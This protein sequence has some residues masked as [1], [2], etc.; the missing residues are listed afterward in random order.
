MSSEEFH[1]C[2]RNWQRL[3]GFL[4]PASWYRDLICCMLSV[5]ASD[6]QLP[7]VWE[8]CTGHSQ[9]GE[10]DRRP[11]PR[12]CFSCCKRVVLGHHDD[13]A[14]TN[15]PY[16]EFWRQNEKSKSLTLISRTHRPF[17]TVLYLNWLILRKSLRDWICRSVIDTDRLTDWLTNS[18]TN[19]LGPFPRFF[20]SA[21]LARSHILFAALTL[22]TK[23][24]PLPKNNNGL[25]FSNSSHQSARR[26]NRWCDFSYP[27]V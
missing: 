27:V 8:C 13:Y 11:T 15:Q 9:E 6:S 22:I 2:W 21:L 12:N 18:I 7:T 10:T 4:R 25:V 23:H 5:H 24:H 26:T 17:A 14:R 1:S 19:A 3:S 16:F 20:L